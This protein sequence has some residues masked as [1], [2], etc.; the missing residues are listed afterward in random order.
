MLI[1]VETRPDRPP[2]CVPPPHTH[3][4]RTHTPHTHTHTHPFRAPSALHAYAVFRAPRLR[5]RKPTGPPQGFERPPL[6][7]SPDTV[8]GSGSKPSAREWVGGSVRACV[9]AYVRACLRGVCACV[10]LR[11]C[12]EGTGMPGPQEALRLPARART[13]AD[14]C[15]KRG[16]GGQEGR[17]RVAALVLDPGKQVCGRPRRQGARAFSVCNVCCKASL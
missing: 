12:V 7:S 15:G 1:G 16:W 11:E 6:P 10:C 2:G 8:T 14:A 17:L 5:G 4:H 13:L 9:P 3:T